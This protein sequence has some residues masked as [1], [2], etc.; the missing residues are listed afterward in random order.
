MAVRLAASVAA[1]AAAAPPPGVGCSE[2]SLSANSPKGVAAVGLVEA[3]IAR[4]L[5][6]W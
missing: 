2:A 6:R 4:I 3:V 5:A 1:T